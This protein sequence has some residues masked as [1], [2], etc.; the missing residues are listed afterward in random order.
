MVKQT[1]TMNMNKEIKKK[2]NHIAID[3]ETTVTEIVTN[4]ILKYIE[5][6]DGK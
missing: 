2:L 6:Y 4:L 3:E 1:F 5:E